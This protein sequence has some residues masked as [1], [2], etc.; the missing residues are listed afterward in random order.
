[1]RFRLAVVLN[2]ELGLLLVDRCSLRHERVE[3]AL[4]GDGGQRWS[5]AIDE[6]AHVD[7]GELV[8]RR[9]RS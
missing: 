3:R 5:E 7:G 6:A 8:A 1:M 2:F 4:G 9:E